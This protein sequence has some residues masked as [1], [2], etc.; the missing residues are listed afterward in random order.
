M[1]VNINKE[2]KRVEIAGRKLKARDARIV[3]DI[4]TSINRRDAQE[5]GNGGNNAKAEQPRGVAGKT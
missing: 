4:L 1:V 5:A 3:Y 2:G